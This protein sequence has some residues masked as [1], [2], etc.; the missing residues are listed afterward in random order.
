VNPWEVVDPADVRDR[1]GWEWD[2]WRPAVVRPRLLEKQGPPRTTMH[3]VEF[4]KERYPS[5][6][7]TVTC[8]AGVVAEYINKGSPPPERLLIG[9]D[10]EWI[11]LRSGGY[12]LALLQLCVGSRCLIY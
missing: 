8:D 4:F 12:K 2:E 7:T 9:L 10:T 5:I 1:S 11:E 3:E 6:K